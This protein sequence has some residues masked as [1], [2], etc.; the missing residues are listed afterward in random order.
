MSHRYYPEGTLLSQT[1]NQ[2][3]L[4]SRS[5][6]E[7]A[8]A[9]QRI[10]EGTVLLCD[11]HLNLHVDLGC[12]RGIVERQEAVYCRRGE[13][14]KD[15]AVIT[16]VG[17]PICFRVL[18]FTQMG[19]ET[20]ARLS[21]R[22]AQRECLSHYLAH[23]RPG[24]IL[25]ATVTHMEPFG[26]F[27]DIGCGVSS[28]L[29]V[30]CLSVSRI[31]HPSDRLSV[32][33]RI[34]TVVKAMDPGLERI[35]VSM[36]ELLGTWEENAARFEVGQTV[37]GIVRSVE[38]YGVFVELTPNLAGLAELREGSGDD[39]LARV[40]TAAAVYVKSM[41]PDRMKIKLVLID[42][43]RGAL[44]RSGITYFV[45]CEKVSHLDLWRYSPA[46]SQKVIETR[47]DSLG[48]N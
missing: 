27:V 1:E 37:P 40:G 6:L 48:I 33:D 19:D 47:F 30:D 14:W 13:G 31:S 15:I 3:F 2:E 5:A 23:L 36:R 42:S 24:D 4:S 17:K 9:E 35:F 43:Y 16:R 45:D 26:A 22:E 25:P 11:S 39:A 28:L 7:R 41:I 8:A 38:S 20:V 34:Y 12:M 29:S 10:L 44:P 46:S 21:R 18:G 32:G